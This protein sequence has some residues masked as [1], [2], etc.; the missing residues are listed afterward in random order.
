MSIFTYVKSALVNAIREDKTE[1]IVDFNK[2]YPINVIRWFC[3]N[4]IFKVDFLEKEI[5]NGKKVYHLHIKNIDVYNEFLKDTY[6]QLEKKGYVGEFK[7]QNITTK[8]SNIYMKYRQELECPNWSSEPDEYGYRENPNG[9][10][11][12]EKLDK[13]DSC[14][15]EAYICSQL[16]YESYQQW[17]DSVNEQERKALEEAYENEAEE[18]KAPEYIYA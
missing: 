9:E 16:G 7:D 1:G 13:A 18:I 5:I 11:G 8:F 4:G 3:K 12:Y 2:G 10:I 6:E 14:T 15:F 17:V